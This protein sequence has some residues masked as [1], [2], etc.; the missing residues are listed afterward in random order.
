MTSDRPIPNEQTQPDDQAAVVQA[1]ASFEAILEMFPEDVSALESLVGAYQATGQTDKAVEKSLQLA[2]LMA[3]EGNWR[4][5]KTITQSVLDKDGDNTRARILFDTACD[6][7][8]GQASVEEVPAA[9]AAPRPTAAAGGAL[10]F[11]INIELELAWF[12]L[13]NEII[14]QEQ[15]ES[16]ISGLTNSRT[17]AQAGTSLSLL[18][19][20]ANIER[21]NIDRVI[22]ALSAQTETPYIDVT[23]VEIQPE[24]AELVPLEAAR[25]LG[26]LPFGRLRNDVMVAVLNPVS[27]GLRK[28][29]A[30][31]LQQQVHIF[32]TGPEQLHSA[33]DKL[34]GIKK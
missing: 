34:A 6:S 18:Q 2:D 20:L 16:A 8:V 21:V 12:L 1:I 13:N 22:G 4:R 31:F 7:L 25:G 29:L 19:E 33:V 26:V 15:Y 27:T 9:A 14:T 24:V 17:K 30:S 32:L 5:V 28:K 11:D 23:R 3:Q 10:E